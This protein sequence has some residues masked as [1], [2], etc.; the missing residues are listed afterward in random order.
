MP[1]A[2]VAASRSRTGFPF[3]AALRTLMRTSEEGVLVL[4]PRGRVR[5]LN[6]A[7]A[8]MLGVRARQVLGQPGSALVRTAVPADDPARDARESARI[9]RETV[10][11]RP[12]GSGTPASTAIA[13]IAGPPR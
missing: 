1:P 6:A 2:I 12:D 4:D 3:E 8:R 13:R 5:A 10:V 9:E 7:A 11:L